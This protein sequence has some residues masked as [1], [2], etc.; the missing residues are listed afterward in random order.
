[1]S[2]C[3]RGCVGEEVG[4]CRLH[5]CLGGQCERESGLSPPHEPLVVARLAPKASGC[6]SMSGFRV[7]PPSFWR[8]EYL[9]P[10]TPPTLPSP[11]PGNMDSKKN[12]CNEGV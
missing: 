1:M 10:F 11:F 12:T 4:E 9:P 2:G 7:L 8:A 3:V 5:G 6:K